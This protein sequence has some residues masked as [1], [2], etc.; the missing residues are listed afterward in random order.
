MPSHPG[1]YGHLDNRTGEQILVAR[2]YL[3][4]GGDVVPY[5][6]NAG[7]IVTVITTADIASINLPDYCLLFVE[8]G[9]SQP[10]DP[11]EAFVNAALPQV[12]A[13]VADGGDVMYYTGTWGAQYSFPGS[14]YSVYDYQSVNN[15]CNPGHPIAAGVPD[16]FEGNY[17]SHEYFMDLPAG[18]TCIM[19]DQTGAWTGAEYNYGSGHVILMGQPVEC[20]LVGGNCESLGLMH[21]ETLLDNSMQYATRCDTDF[22]DADEQPTNF[23]LAQNHPNPFNPVTTIDFSLNET[24]FASLTIYDLQ[25]T[26][27]AQPVN[28]MTEGGEHQISFDASQLA[29]GIYFYSLEAN[30]QIATRRMTL[31]K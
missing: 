19:T 3:P 2:D 6:T 5:L 11:T 25:G 15:F 30:N 18:A 4:W 13:F 26:M 16:P 10:G 22:V 8:C 17:A 7:A 21:F 24:G 27:V 20:Y 31:I 29:S 28:G 1:I 9:T 23:T 12:E 14:G